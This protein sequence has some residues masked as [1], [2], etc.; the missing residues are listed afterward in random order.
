[1]DERSTET[2]ERE[3]RRN[4]VIIFGQKESGETL[5][6]NRHIKELVRTCN[7]TLNVVLKTDD[8]V[9]SIRLDKIINGKPRPLKVTFKEAGTKQKIFTNLHKLKQA[10][11]DEDEKLS[12]IHDLT[13][14][15]REEIKQLE[16]EAE[17]KTKES[18]GGGL[19]HIQSE[20]PTVELAHKENGE[21]TKRRP[22]IED[23]RRN[24][25]DIDMVKTL[26][27]QNQHTSTQKNQNKL[28]CMY[29][30]ADSLLNK[31]FRRIKT[32]IL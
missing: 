24:M 7:N 28:K 5:K 30:N 17:N 32:Q 13:P 4:N 15:Q 12:I 8:C 11:K 31:I 26:T 22:I 20:R 29:T 14:Q 23:S 6:G 9:N 3:T 18:G 27:K 19:T 25:K 21:K 10:Q 1:M 2:K 16:K